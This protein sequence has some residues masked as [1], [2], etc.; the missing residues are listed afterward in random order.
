MHNTGSEPRP[1]HV[2]AVPQEL[3]VGAAK[4]EAVV[5]PAAAVFAVGVGTTIT[6][7][8]SFAAAGR[9]S[10]LCVRRRAGAR[11]AICVRKSRAPLRALSGVEQ[12][13][14]AQAPAGALAHDLLPA[15][16]LHRRADRGL[17]R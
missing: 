5:V 10:A 13:A 14:F 17:I 2:D 9:T 4:T 16:V 8:V 6:A 11:R 1:G 7:V 12:A 3:D 15:G